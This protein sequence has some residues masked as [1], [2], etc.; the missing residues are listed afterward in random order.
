M[1]K[2]N[3]SLLVTAETLET[4]HIPEKERN[5][6]V[7]G[8]YDMKSEAERHHDCFY[9]LEAVYSHPFTYGT[10][11]PGFMNMSWKDFQ[12]C[13]TLKGISQTTFEMMQSFCKNP[14]IVTLGTEAEFKKKEEPQAHTGYCNPTGVTDFVNDMASWEEWH[15]KWNV[16]HQDQIDWRGVNDQWLPRPDLI[17]GILRRELI[18]NLDKGEAER[19][20]DADVVNVFYDR[21]MK[22]KGDETEAYASRIGG[23]ICKCN[24]YS[25]EAELSTLEQKYAKSLREIYSIINQDGKIQFVSIDFLHGMFEF[26]SENGEH[27]GEF[28]F[29]GSYNKC[30]EVSHNFKCM[31][32]WH[33]QTGKY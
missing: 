10:F 14:V 12:E 9:A 16:V 6:A 28:R 5:K 23:E 20:K 26:H 33:K 32:L 24:Y 8:F 22:H 19:I 31:D 1:V 17:H 13:K 2:V 25:Y 15:R 4:A 29:D 30:R 27:Q 18:A 21:V 3:G 11:Y 7:L